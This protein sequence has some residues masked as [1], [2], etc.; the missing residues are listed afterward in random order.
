MVEVRDVRGGLVTVTLTQDELET[1][2][3]ICQQA[4]IREAQASLLGRFFA[5]AAVAAELANHAPVAET[6]AG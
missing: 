5:L 3:R 1:L 4:S 6:Q 2:A